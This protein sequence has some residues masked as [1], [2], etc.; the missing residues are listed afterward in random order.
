MSDPTKSIFS[1]DTSNLHPE[2]TALFLDFDGT[3]APIVEHPDAV[4][5]P[6]NTMN[7]IAWLAKTSALAIVT[8]R[9]IDDID[10]FMSPLKLPVAGVHGL[11]RR[12]A[13]G[14]IHGAPISEEELK[15]V[16]EQLATF[17]IRNPGLILEPKRGSIALHYRQRPDLAGECAA[18]V[19][20]FTASFSEL[21]VLPGKMVLEIKA[22]F[23]TKG[24]AIR[25]FMSEVPFLGRQPFFAGDDVTDEEAFPAVSRRGGIT[26][27]IGEGESTA[28]YR[29]SGP[30][31]F[32][33]WLTALAHSYSSS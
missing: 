11:E 1:L 19:A 13:D 23:A 8:G 32:S 24:D 2:R 22:G 15:N 10:R 33:E 16:S 12:S 20:E 4:S 5:V 6:L 3:L 30:E 25:A 21:D 18:A 14:V 28:M 26:V 31:Q 7:A 29:S 9:R 17:V 27:R